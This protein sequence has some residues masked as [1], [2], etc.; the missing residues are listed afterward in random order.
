MEA[1]LLAKEELLL[2]LAALMAFF[3]SRLFHFHNAATRLFART[4]QR[5]PTRSFVMLSSISAF[6]S[7]LARS[8]VVFCCASASMLLQAQVQQATC[9]FTPFSIS[10]VPGSVYFSVDGINNWGT[11]VG[12]A[13]FAHAPTQGYARY[14]D[15]SL[16]FY[17]V[18]NSLFTYFTARNNRKVSVG[19]Y[20]LIGT[21]T[22]K[23]F[24]LDGST[25]TSISF[26]KRGPRGTVATGINKWNTV[27]GYYIDSN[28]VSHGFKR[29]SNG[30]FITLDYP[31]AI[32]TYP[33]A[34]NNNGVI[35]GSYYDGN[36]GTHGFIYQNGQ[37]TG[38]DRVVDLGNT[39]LSGI[40]DSGVAVGN[41]NWRVNVPFLY[42]HG[43]YKDMD[44]PAADFGNTVATGMAS[45]GLIVGYETI[46]SVQNNFT[47]T[48]Q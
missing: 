23:G 33:V 41:W 26:P 38:V 21:V 8:T 35:A 15:G 12:S 42:D 28:K 27:V 13:V 4:S 24:M 14:A 32:D 16:Q 10:N 7:R 5:R 44:D 9:S 22:L 40:S 46:N 30:S 20:A 19:Y 45:N 29:F 2:T 48:C 17:L 39:S 34:I 36:P 11:V 6:M 31:G 43:V 47:A 18:P 25:L 37:W 3:K 1:N